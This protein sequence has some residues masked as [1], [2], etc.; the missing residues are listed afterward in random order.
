[1]IDSLD[2]QLK[3]MDKITHGENVIIRVI[4]ELVK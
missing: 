1:M 2:M 4:E 3:M